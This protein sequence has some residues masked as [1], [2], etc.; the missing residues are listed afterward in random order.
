MNLWPFIQWS[1]F[2]SLY[3]IVLKKGCME[4]IEE[5]KVLNHKNNWNFFQEPFF[6]SQFFFC[7][8]TSGHNGV[9]EQEHIWYAASD[10]L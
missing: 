7:Y 8:K 10:T 4:C 6:L 5:A 1:L 3:E 2:D 9:I